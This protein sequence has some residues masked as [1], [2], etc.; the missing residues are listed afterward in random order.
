MQRLSKEIRE[1]YSEGDDIMIIADNRLIERM[2]KRVRQIAGEVSNEESPE[3]YLQCSSLVLAFELKRI[4]IKYN[5]YIQSW[6]TFNDACAEGYNADTRD[7][8]DASTY[9]LIAA[10]TEPEAV[11]VAFLWLADRQNFTASVKKNII[12]LGINS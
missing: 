8:E 9:C 4:A 6:V 2:L 12:K 7:D 5:C 11:V 10:P 1:G 3:Y